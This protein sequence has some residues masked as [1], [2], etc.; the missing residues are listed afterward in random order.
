M[1][2]LLYSSIYH[3][4]QIFRGSQ[5]SRIAISKHF[6]ETVFAD[7]ELRVYGLLKFHELNFRGLLGIRGNHG[8]YALQKFGCIE[9]MYVCTVC[10][11]VCMYSRAG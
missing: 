4:G 6:A 5:F 3:I 7:Q 8:N 11:Y 2:I 10:M 1:Y 9:Y